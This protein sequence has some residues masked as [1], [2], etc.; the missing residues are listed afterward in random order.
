M[1]PTKIKLMSKITHER[2]G[3]SKEYFDAF[4]KGKSLQ[5]VSDHKYFVKVVDSNGEHWHVHNEILRV[6]DLE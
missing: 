1:K 2:F 6:V 4:I 3:C 5:I